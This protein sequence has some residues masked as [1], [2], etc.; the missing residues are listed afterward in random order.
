MS[1]E[2]NL[3]PYASEYGSAQ[4]SLEIRALLQ[5]LTNLP[6][7]LHRLI[8]PALREAGQEIL[9]TAAIDSMWS[10]R[11]PHALELRVSLASRR[12]GVYIRVNSKKAPHAR[13]FEGL[14]ADSWRHPVF[15][16]RD[17]WVE[18]RARPFLLPAVRRG[19]PAARA[20]IADAVDR[21]IAQQGF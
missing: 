4:S 17:T 5:A 21:A 14:L 20:L 9:R 10:S 2:Q 1:G 8:R 15:G 11:I 19:A 18:Q 12:P 3:R 16:N 13:P 6:K 7:D